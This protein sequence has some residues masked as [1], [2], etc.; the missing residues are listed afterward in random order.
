MKMGLSKKDQK[1]TIYNWLVTVIL[2]FDKS[3]YDTF[4]NEMKNF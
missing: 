4:Q 1:S 3:S 2:L